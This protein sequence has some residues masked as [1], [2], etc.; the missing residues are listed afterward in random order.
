MF[1]RR[2]IVAPPFLC[3]LFTQAEHT[4]F[5]NTRDGIDATRRASSLHG[6][7]YMTVSKIDTLRF[8]SFDH[9]RW[10]PSLPHATL[11]ELS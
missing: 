10:F 8:A 7:F 3:P 4:C 6:Q 9:R 11:R 5:C 1:V 2:R